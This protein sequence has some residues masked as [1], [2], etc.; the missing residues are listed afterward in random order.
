MLEETIC[1]LRGEEMSERVEPEI[2]LKVP[3]FIPEAYVKDPGQRLVIYKK[4]TQAENEED[5][6][7][8]QNEVSDRFGSYPLA[9]AFLFDIMKLRILLKRLLVRQIDFDGKSVIISFHPRTP[10]PP[11][12]IIAMMR[13]E[14]KKFLFTPDYKL[15]CTLKGT[16]FEDILIESKRILMR[17]IPHNNTADNKEN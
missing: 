14:P 16:S 1:R 10:A 17:L 3:A 12:T 5:V 15:V 6:L 13:N 11:D 7:E 4:L 8:V 9:T 2:N